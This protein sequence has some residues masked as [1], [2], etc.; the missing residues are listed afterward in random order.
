M[1]L[2]MV[3]RLELLKLLALVVSGLALLVIGTVAA[4]A[5]PA[6]AK[7]LGLRGLKRQRALQDVPFWATLEPFVRWLSARFGGLLSKEQRGSLNRKLALAGDFMGLMPEEIVGFSILTS[8]LGGGVG[9]VLG[10]LSGLGHLVFFAG[11]LVGAALPNMRISNTAIERM[12]EVSRRLPYA[13]DLLSLSMGAGLDFPG[14]VR[15]VVNKCGASDDPV[16]E[17]FTLILQSLQLGRT[18]R[19]ALETFAERVPIDGVVEFVGAM[20][21]AE[22]R[23]NPVVDVLRIQADVARKK[24]TVR[25][26]EAAAKAGAAML[27]PLVLVFL[28]IMILIIAPIVMKVQLS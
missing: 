15:Q 24:R 26:E 14:A 23:G 16:V 4:A 11:V 20:V 25:A 10:A 5:P 22:L 1:N 7:R 17:E 9:Y 27:G 28:A 19:S 18:R 6:E 2:A 3:E 21:Q 12:K 13:I 8:L